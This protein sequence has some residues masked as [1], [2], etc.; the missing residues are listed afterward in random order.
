MCSRP[1]SATY[2]GPYTKSEHTAEENDRSVDAHRRLWNA[3]HIHVRLHEPLGRQDQA[4]GGQDQDDQLPA[5][6][7]L[8]PA[9][10]GEV[11][12]DD[13]A[14][15]G[16]AQGGE[17]QHLADVYVAEAVGRVDIEQGRRDKVGGEEAVRRRQEADGDGTEDGPVEADGV[18]D[19]QDGNLSLVA[20]LE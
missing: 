14:E 3:L 11:A 13:H 9:P 8:A 10:V 4:D 7:P 17:V 2:L 20:V 15:E 5:V 12:K 1:D 16:G 18:E 19:A 6:E